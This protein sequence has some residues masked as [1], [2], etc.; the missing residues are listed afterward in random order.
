MVPFLEY[1]KHKQA[2]SCR[3]VSCNHPGP[4]C[5]EVMKLKDYE[6][7]KQACAFRLVLC[8]AP[9]CTDTTSIS[10]L[11]EHWN[12]CSSNCKTAERENDRIWGECTNTA[13]FFRTSRILAHGKTFFLKIKNP[14]DFNFF[15]VV[16]V[17]TETECEGFVASI[18]VV[19]KDL[20]DFASMSS[21]PRPLDE[22]AWGQMGLTLSKK[23]MAKI[24]LPRSIFSFKMEVTICKL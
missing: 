5:N 17:G 8:P 16:M 19:D 23:D 6:K 3:L 21:Y 9:S 15:E 14:A 18:I 12:I 24:T 1:E 20:K 2:C 4:G 22:Q 11:E 10:K 13:G 7:H